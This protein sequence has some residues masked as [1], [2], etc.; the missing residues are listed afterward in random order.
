MDDEI[1]KQMRLLLKEIEDNEKSE[2][3][4]FIDKTKAQKVSSGQENDTFTTEFREKESRRK[5]VQKGT[6]DM[7]NT[8]RTE[9]GKKFWIDNSLSEWPE[10][11]YRIH[12]RN[13]PVTAFESD[14]YE[15]FKHF[16]SLSKIKVIHDS[17]GRSRQYGFI[18]FLDVNDYIEAMKT[19]NNTI[20]QSRRIRLL[21]SK[22]KDKSIEN[23]K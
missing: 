11:D 16:K 10:N 12:V 8:F 4:G 17:S 22:W 1:E 9:E 20:I 21:P 18:S 19:M 23:A 5:V 3:K 6:Q 13:L 7:K 2:N 15:A 14:L